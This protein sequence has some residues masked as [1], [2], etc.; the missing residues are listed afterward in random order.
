[1]N[2][3]YEVCKFMQVYTLF[4]ANML[5]IEVNESRLNTL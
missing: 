3:F 4:S 2:L 1:M 5:S